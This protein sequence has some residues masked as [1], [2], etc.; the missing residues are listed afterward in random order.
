MNN[1]NCLSCWKKTKLKITHSH[2]VALLLKL[3]LTLQQ[4]EDQIYSLYFHVEQHCLKVPTE[5]ST[6]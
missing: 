2:R 6:S 1:L 3:C 5:N 4:L